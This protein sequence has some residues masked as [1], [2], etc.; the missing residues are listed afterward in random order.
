MC[1]CVFSLRL[2]LAILSFFQWFGTMDE[3]EI[4]TSFVC[5]CARE[6]ERVFYHT[7]SESVLCDLFRNTFFGMFRQIEKICY[8][9]LYF[10]FYFLLLGGFYF[11]FC[12]VVYRTLQSKFSTDLWMYKFVFDCKRFVVAGVG[13]GICKCFSCYMS[14]HLDG[15][16]RL[17]HHL[18]YR[19]PFTRIPHT[20]TYIYLTAAQQKSM[21]FTENCNW[22]C[23][24]AVI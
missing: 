20:S 17:L 19:H 13:G 5:A 15:A 18:L 21:H 9:Y 2:H 16:F 24:C 6:R 7:M 23:W 14:D 12:L 22:C 10:L 8:R 1:E 4:F 3:C 11:I